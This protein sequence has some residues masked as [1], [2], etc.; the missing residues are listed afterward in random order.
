MSVE[1]IQE[2][3]QK[4]EEAS[5]NPEFELIGDSLDK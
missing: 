4:A 2:W 5:V 3:I 1:Y